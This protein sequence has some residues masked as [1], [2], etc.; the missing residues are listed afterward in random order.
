MSLKAYVAPA[1][2]QNARK[3]VTAV[4][5]FVGFKDV[6]EKNSAAKTKVFFTQ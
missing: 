4:A 6:G 2:A 3:P 1:A 5:A